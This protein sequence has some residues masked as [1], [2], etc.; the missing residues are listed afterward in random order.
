M[1]VEINRNLEYWIN[2]RV[3]FFRFPGISGA[4]FFGVAGGMEETGFFVYLCGPEK[5][6]S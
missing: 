2:I 6:G 5:C 4:S 3:K 1:R